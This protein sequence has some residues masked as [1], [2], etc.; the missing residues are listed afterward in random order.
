MEKQNKP[1]GQLIFDCSFDEMVALGYFDHIVVNGEPTLRM[2]KKGKAKFAMELRA[3][4]LLHSKL[5]YDG[6]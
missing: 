4:A 3:L 6:M 2:T 1:I 5:E